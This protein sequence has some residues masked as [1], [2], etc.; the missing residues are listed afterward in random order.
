MRLGVFA[1]AGLAALSLAA[2]VNTNA[3]LLGQA[4][5]RGPVDPASVEIYRTAAQVPGGFTELALIHASGDSGMTDERRLYRSLRAEAAR[6]GADAIILD[7]LSDYN[8]SRQ[9]RAIAIVL[10][11]SP[12][13]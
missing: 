13:S 12:P 1:A 3:T 11:G 5:A 6:L 9:G 4:R 8:A 10:T 7:G 2:C